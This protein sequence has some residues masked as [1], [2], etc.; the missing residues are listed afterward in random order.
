MS[1]NRPE[2]DYK[3][4]WDFA[5]EKTGGNPADTK[6]MVVDLYREI[7]LGRI[8]V[9]GV[10]LLQDR[11]GPHGPG[12][13][14]FGP[15]LREDMALSALGE[16]QIAKLGMDRALSELA[17]WNCGDYE[18]NDRPTRYQFWRDPTEIPKHRNRGFC[19][20][21]EELER[22]H[23]ERLR[24]VVKLPKVQKKRGPKPIIEFEKFENEVHR[25]LKDNGTP[26]PRVDPNFRQADIEEH[27]LGKYKYQ[28]S[29]NRELVQ[30]SIASYLAKFEPNT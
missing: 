22:W 6:V 3:S 16:V 17:K 30:R 4:I 5:W 11:V 8:G 12:A 29:W 10:I 27:M 7:W 26:D 25:L 18:K 19:I 23:A 15:F 9:G 13:E 20:D 28:E 2:R 1:V 21:H 14:Q 24:P